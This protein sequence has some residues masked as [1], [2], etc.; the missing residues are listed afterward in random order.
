MTDPGAGVPN[1]V[2]SGNAIVVKKRRKQEN[3]WAVWACCSEALSVALVVHLAQS[4][5]QSTEG[6]CNDVACTPK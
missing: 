5:R 4:E 2:C 6:M 3:I 1:W